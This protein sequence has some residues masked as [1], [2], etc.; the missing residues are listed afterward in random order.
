MGT[1]IDN[2]QIEIQSSSTNAAKGIDDLASS[3]ERLKSNG[4]FKSVSTNL[5][6]LSTA[7][8]NLP[9]VHNASNSLRTLANSIEKLKSV[10]TV[11][12]LTNSLSKLPTALKSLDNINLERAAPQIQKVVDALGPLS[13]MKSGGIGTMV[14]SL[15]NL[16]KV[17]ESLSEE[18]ITK[19]AAKIKELDTHLGPLSQKMTTI[20]A[21]LKG[22]NASFKQTSVAV[23]NVNAKVKV[24]M[25]NLANLTTVFSAVSGA[26]QTLIQKFSNAVHQ[27][28]QWDG[29][30]YQF[31]NAFGEQADLYYEKITMIT[32]ALKLDK[33]M[34]MENSAM[35]TSMLTGFG[36]NN[37]DARKMGLGYTE[38]AYD[39]WA[40]Y[41][42]VYESFDGADGVM[43]AIRSAIAGEVEPIRRAGFTIVESTLEQTA[44]NHGLEISIEKATEAQK[45]YLRYLSLVDQAQ[46][47]GVI[48]TYASEMKTAEGMM[49]TFSQQL[50]SLTRAFGSLFIPILVKVMPYVQAFVELLQEGVFWLAGLL[51]VEIQKV[52]FSDYKTGKDA[53][54]GVGDAAGTT[55]DQLGEATKAAKELKNATLGIDELNVI[56]PTSSTGSSGSGS[57]VGSGGGGFEGLDVDSLWDQTIFDSIQSD[58]DAIKEKLRGWMPVIAGVGTALAGLKLKNLLDDIDIAGFKLSNLGKVVSVAGITIAVGK[59]VWDFTGAYLEGGNEADLL[60]A[61]GTT[62]LGVALA[63]YLAGK[64][65]AS[66]T[67]LVSRVRLSGTTPKV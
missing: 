58:V 2:I 31:G 12:G 13:S 63:G 27:A 41:N 30:E 32:D 42:N 44:A 28:S 59:L 19:F 57:G 53:V 15:K 20:Q 49:R 66:F 56:S 34:F 35:A 7:L 26:L 39:I 4:A 51:G 47:K 3:L 64:P 67:L 52:D 46:S 10:G 18:S 43:A 9:N 60:K 1:T 50:S 17:T 22:L 5:N 45:S 33:Q 55:A 48:G 54:A 11:S 37:V 6:H 24:N 62:A 40:A 36:V 65:G 61:L 29:V 25:F 14:N 38:L 16:D 8:K 23:D 21:G